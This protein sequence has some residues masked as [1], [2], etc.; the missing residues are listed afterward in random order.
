MC[1][2]LVAWFC[3]LCYYIRPLQQRAWMLIET[4][5][6][7]TT[8]C[9][10]SMLKEGSC[11]CRKFNSIFQISRAATGS[12]VNSLLNIS[13]SRG[14]VSQHTG[15]LDDLSVEFCVPPLDKAGE[16]SYPG[17]IGILLITSHSLYARMENDPKGQRN[18]WH[19]P[20]SLTSNPTN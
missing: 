14:H 19:L 4:A 6:S 1:M 20:P 12:N 16:L 8:W 11:F 17:V 13:I 18:S 15:F 9:D 10:L 3:C 5:G 2:V 7:H